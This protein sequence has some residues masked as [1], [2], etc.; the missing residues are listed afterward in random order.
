MALTTKQLQALKAGEWVSDGGARGAGTLVFRRTI[1]GERLAYFRYT[2]PNKKR[3]TLPIG[4]YDEQG[5]SGLSLT[6][7]RTKA[8][9]L[10]KLYKA[11]IKDLRSH[12]DSLKIAKTE[13]EKAASEADAA[14]AEDVIN[15]QRFT[16]R[17]LCDEYCKFL[18]AKGKTESARQARS[19]L[20]CHVYNAFPAIAALPANEVTAHQI[21][22][23]IRMVADQGKKRA[24][25]TLRSYLAAA[26]SNA[27]K[28]PYDPL[29]PKAFIA[30]KVDVNPVTPIP[31][32]PVN[33][34]ERVL[35][36]S[37][38][39]TYVS[40]LGSSMPDMALKLA[41]YSGGQRMAQILR[42]KV[43][44]FDPRSKIL[45]LW[46]TKGKRPAPREHLI[47]L[48][49][50]GAMLVSHLIDLANERENKRAK[51]EGRQPAIASCWLFS[52]GQ[53]PLIETTPGKRLK[54][55]CKE[56]PG[57]TFDLRDIRRTCETTL[58][59]LRVDKD[60]RA[61]LLSHGLSGVQSAHYDRYEYIDEKHSALII[62]EN[63]LNELSNES[64]AN[65]P[66]A[67]DIIQKT[68]VEK[69]AQKSKLSIS[70]D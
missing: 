50:K 37:E 41:L 54:E 34:G 66:L 14:A 40:K 69:P 46:D 8:G 12:F 39:K 18:I 1:S 16:L 5:I 67:S 22:E 27:R 43:S 47:P 7:A 30:Y 38:L 31:A 23:M 62:W 21:A 53:N 24:P 70:K 33:R 60:T 44:D 68:S 55:I 56:M 49:D 51:T 3:D 2:L 59:R 42:A 28:A 52:N 65:S 20:T 36:E 26:Y 13:A 57:S 35:I 32:I 45:R 11:G 29:T 63:F 10:S 15:K 19:I 25:G 61:Q 4:N 48:C 6:E 58:A 9:E 64:P 17:A